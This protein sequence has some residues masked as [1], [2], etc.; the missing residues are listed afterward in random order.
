MGDMKCWEFNVRI[1]VWVEVSVRV[2]VVVSV[3]VWVKVSV[4]V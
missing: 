1:G 3:G 2:K 4:R